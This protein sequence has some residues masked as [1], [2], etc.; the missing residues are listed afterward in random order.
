MQQA[1]SSGVVVQGNSEHCD[2]ST[3]LSQV[4]FLK[5]KFRQE[6]EQGMR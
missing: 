6:Q 3:D 1:L 5:Q 4:D 2:L